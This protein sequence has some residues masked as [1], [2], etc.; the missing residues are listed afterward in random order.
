[1]KK[2]LAVF[3]MLA[4]SF[5]VF[6]QAASESSD[7]LKLGMVTDSG[8]IDDRSFNQGTW[9]GIARAGEE[10]GLECTYLRPAGTTS[11][12]YL[13][14]IS[15]LYDQG[16]RFIACPGYLFVEAVS[17]AQQMYDDL[18]IIIID[19]AMASGIGE[20]TV[21]ITF[22]E[23]E[24]GFL[25]GIATALKLGEG[26]VGFVG[27]LEIPAVQKFNWGFQQGITY[28]NE[29]L[30]TTITM[31]PNNFVYSG[32]FADLALG[33]QL[34]TAMYD[35]GVDVIFAAAGG[36]GVGVINEAK[37]RRLSGEDVWAVGV[38]VDQYTVG[39]MGNGESCV[40]TSAMKDVAGVAYDQAV[41]A[42]N[43]TYEG[44]RHIELGI[45]EDRAGI[46]AENPNLTPEI[47]AQV[48][49]VIELIKAGEVTV[50]ATGDG[51]IK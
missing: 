44:G 13:T 43:G 42:A 15:D 3:L 25:A 46:P 5:S 9:E 12:D 41:A 19:D 23:N 16:Y 38:D 35:S 22:R 51:L 7:A 37:N 36:T 21:A 31:N 17:Q 32:S 24:A 30:G 34:A 11:T 28:A 2:L 48:D 50:Q 6:A 18:K 8:T 47:E 40:L 29:N 1:M 27:G 45:A 10:L 4:L 49:A 26:E 39:D 33:Q 14:A 20:N